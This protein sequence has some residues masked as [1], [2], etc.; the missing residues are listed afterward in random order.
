MD[1]KWKEK[2]RGGGRTA[3]EGKSNVWRARGLLVGSSL[4]TLDSSG[5]LRLELVVEEE[6]GL[7]ALEEKNSKRE[8]EW[9]VTCTWRA[10]SLAAEQTHLDS[11][12]PTMVNILSPVSS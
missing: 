9:S 11:G 10:H 2:Q 7:L 8:R 3:K 6:E 5:L 4:G 12:D 1:I